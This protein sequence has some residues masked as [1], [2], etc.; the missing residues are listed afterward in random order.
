MSTSE[1]LGPRPAGHHAQ[2]A[3]RPVGQPSWLPHGLHCVTVGRGRRA[4][5]CLGIGAGGGETEEDRPPPTAAPPSPAPSVPS[6]RPLERR[7]GGPTTG[8]F[9]KLET[10]AEVLNPLFKTVPSSTQ[11][12]GLGG[13]RAASEG[14]R[15]RWSCLTKQ[16][17]IL[18][19]PGSWPGLTR[20]HRQTF[21]PGGERG[22][23]FQSPA[24]VSCSVS[25]S[26]RKPLDLRVPGSPPAAVP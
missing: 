8:N 2:R 18:P 7:A 11:R 6:Q 15:G 26:I 20:G 19:R 21:S 23:D 12:A 9:P 10:P 1:L 14:L 16:M 13:H 3:D 17:A 24:L 5:A 22:R 25:R 4:H